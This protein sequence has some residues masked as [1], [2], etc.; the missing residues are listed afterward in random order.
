MAAGDGWLPSLAGGALAEELAAD[1]ADKLLRLPRLQ[2]V[3][4]DGRFEASMKPV[5]APPGAP[6]SIDLTRP[7]HLG[8][9]CGLRPAAVS[10]TPAACGQSPQV[11]HI[12]HHSA[13]HAANCAAH[14]TTQACGPGAPL[15][16]PSLAQQLFES[17]LAQSPFGGRMSP[18]QA[19]SLGGGCLYPAAA[20]GGSAY[21]EPSGLL[22]S[23]QQRRLGIQSPL[24][25]A[26]STTFQ[27]QSN[28]PQSIHHTTDAAP[29]TSDRNG[30]DWAA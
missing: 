19:V 1:R 5:F 4:L 17:Q 30:I 7:G 23:V 18:G 24:P 6:T 11:A 25:E 14:A 20:V 27:P 28:H 12:A 21:M 16:A 2:Q 15:V 13:L 29:C 10:A 8:G 9:V 26:A 22:P 3:Q